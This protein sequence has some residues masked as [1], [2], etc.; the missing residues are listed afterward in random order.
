[1]SSRHPHTLPSQ[2]GHDTGRAPGQEARR[3]TTR[4]HCSSR[5]VPAIPVARFACDRARSRR[6]ATR[7]IELYRRPVL[8][9]E[10]D[11]R[12]PRAAVRPLPDTAAARPRRCR[13][14]ARHRGDQ[15]LR[16]TAGRGRARGGG[17]RVGF[18]RCGHVAAAAGVLRGL[19]ACTYY[20]TRV[21]SV[22]SVSRRGGNMHVA[23]CGTGRL[24]PT[25]LARIR[26]YCGS[27]HPIPMHAPTTMRSFGSS[28]SPCVV[29]LYVLIG[30]DSYSA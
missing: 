21:F 1:M 30:I 4:T 2:Q 29:E 11:A 15:R 28:S 18:V 5:L 10:H 23:T 19:R 3:K 27:S 14:R 9:A 26:I 25:P 12:V 24:S 20:A 22:K 16:D 13:A 8:R 17:S 6:P 7:C